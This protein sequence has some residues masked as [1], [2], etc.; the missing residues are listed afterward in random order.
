[1]KDPTSELLYL[2]PEF[3]LFVNTSSSIVLLMPKMG[4]ATLPT[5][6]PVPLPSAEL[7]HL[8]PGITLQPPLSRRGHGPGMI[9]VV[10]DSDK[11][12]IENGIS[13]TETLSPLQKWAEEGFATVEIIGS[14]ISTGLWSLESIQLALDGLTACPSFD[15]ENGVGLIGR[16]IE[17]LKK[18]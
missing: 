16:S 15:R 10:P 17:T 2:R 6:E 7:I 18:A 1:L 3:V 8:G 5:E 14:A 11:P 12:K 4:D 13:E 9:V